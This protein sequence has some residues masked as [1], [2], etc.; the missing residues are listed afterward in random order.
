MFYEA[1]KIKAIKMKNLP[2]KFKVLLKSFL[3]IS[4]ITSATMVN[5]DD[6]EVFYSVNVSK[7]NLLFV[8]DISSSMEETVP[9]SGTASVGT[10]EVK[11]MTFER[12]IAA[13]NDDAEQS[14][15][16]GLYRNSSDLEL[17][18]DGSGQGNKQK[19]GLRFK[20]VDIPKDALITEAYIQ[21]S[22][23]EENYE[24]TNLSIGVQKHN[25]PQSF[26]NKKNKRV[27]DRVL[28]DERVEWNDVPPWTTVQEQGY[29]Q[30]FKGLAPLVRLVVNRSG[31]EKG[32]AIVFVIDGEGKRVADSYEGSSSRAAK[33][34][35]KYL[36]T[37]EDTLGKDKT[38]MKVMQDAFRKVMTEAPD[39]IN[40]GIMNYGQGERNWDG[41]K[42]ANNAEYEN[43]R[44]Y[45]V[46]GVA[47]PVSDANA[48]AWP[49]ISAYESVHNL[50]EPD[51]KS[52]TVND[53][54]ADV[55]D[56]WQFHGGTPTVDALYEA[57][58]YMR[59][60][61][62]HYG[63]NDSRLSGAHPSTYEGNVITDD[64]R[65]VGRSNIVRTDVANAKYTYKS[66]IKSSCQSNY[67]VLMTDGGAHYGEDDLIGPF[68]RIMKGDA[69][70]S[71]LAGNIT[72]CES[73]YENDAGECGKAITHYIAAN[74]NSDDLEG[75][76]TIETF[77]IGFSSGVEEY[78][79]NWLKSLATY[80]DPDTPEGPEADAYFTADDQDK[81]TAAF[82]KILRQVVKPAATFASPGYSVNIKS[83]L[84]HEKFVYIP[85]FDRKNS[86]LWS[87]N[88]KKFEIIDNGDGKRRIQG[89]NGKDAVDELGGFTADAHDFWSSDLA[90]DSSSDDKSDGK[91]ILKGGLANKIDDP[92]SRLLVSNLTS[93]SLLYEE[94]NQLIVKNSSTITNAMLGLDSLASEVNRIQLINFIRGW[95]NGYKHNDET[96]IN[97]WLKNKNGGSST[98]V[99]RKH[100][101]D[102]LHSEPLIITYNKGTA[103][104][105]GKVQYLFAAT[106][107]GYLHAFDT[108]TGVEKFA[109]MPKELLKN[110][111]P[112]FLDAGTANDHKYGID[113]TITYYKTDDG[114]IHL[115]FGLRRGGRSFYALDVTDI[116][117]PKLLWMKTA[118]SN[119]NN[120]LY[121]LGQSWSPPYL[122]KV[123][124]SDGTKKEVVIVSGGYDEKEDRD[125]VSASS[126]VTTT[127]GHDIFIFDAI[128]G[129]RIWSLRKNMANDDIVN[130]IP[131]GIRIL[132]TDSNGQIDRMYFADTGGNVWRLD[133]S[134]MLGSSGSTDTTSKLVKLASLGG[135]GDDARKF[136]NE[137]D[138]SIMKPAGKTIF[139]VSVGS[140]FRAHP[141]DKSI[142]DR[143]FVIK[144][145]SPYSP[146]KTTG[147]GK[148]EAITLS[149][150]AE[151]VIGP[152]NVTQVD[153][154][155][156]S[157]INKGWSVK[158]PIKGE[159][160]LATSVT[161][162]GSVMFTTLVPEA[163]TEGEGIDICKAPITY[164]R[165]YAI[166]ILSGKASHNFDPS[167]DNLETEV[168]DI[169][170]PPLIPVIPG[171]PQL[172]FNKPKID[173]VKDSDDKIIK[174]TCT[175]PVDIRVGKKLTQV[176]GYDACRL[177]S[178][179][180]S[181]PKK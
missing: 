94:D 90:A 154:N 144:D 66:P 82:K 54:L 113:G 44:H 68:A 77:T 72:S 51:D 17:V 49:Y 4:L 173:E 171:K 25:N 65:E 24:E 84:E 3:W 42:Y 20:N 33:L 109:F 177:E 45:A 79:Q 140:G 127:M 155:D 58:L 30:R 115:Y 5:A 57:A 29:D 143:F 8:F 85:V 129:D 123:G 36:G 7:P 170:S 81:L 32:N 137:P 119:P 6:T 2:I 69:S 67:I 116:D 118:S 83:G 159:K 104:G 99:A 125:N 46:S 64:V 43:Y 50:P 55:V 47:F 102:M 11:S 128:T 31:W 145:G 14:K 178:L 23:D 126:V 176:T 163:L 41:W 162:D 139:A 87:G 157:K 34:V 174:T 15:N 96:S 179:Y 40:L 60:E 136:Y 52:I 92:A 121:S 112:Q 26:K 12:R 70:Y 131:G 100:M 22:V 111:E 152:S 27:E 147:E 150:L 172:I 28:Y 89:S 74:D 120:A 160:V 105:T 164:G 21:F 35:V 153:F 78:D 63:K 88:L 86:S 156:G 95:K 168:P 138:V 56:N 108:T 80:N 135:S 71:R 148:Y 13:G 93:S 169:Y 124:M 75:K 38:R 158:L 91:A 37:D 16:E 166:D 62:M 132:D 1:L 165:M 181:D 97:D 114:H 61:T 9:G 10:G 142:E 59:G 117:E 130:S 146:L 167:N 133:L 122:A 106:N 76:Q 19:I 107:E 149:D 53:Y 39:T 98:E 18:Q 175:H 161:V 48:R 180:W 110:I 141:T 73:R 134:E 103:D 151:I 101:G